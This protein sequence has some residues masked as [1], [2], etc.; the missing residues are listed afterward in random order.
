MSRPASA[1]RGTTSSYITTSGITDIVS[2][3]P[4]PSTSN[5]NGRR[6]KAVVQL[7][8]QSTPMCSIESHGQTGVADRGTAGSA[9][10][11]EKA[12]GPRERSRFRR[13]PHYHRRS[14][15]GL[16]RRSCE[17]RRSTRAASQRAG[18]HAA[19][20][21]APNG[22]QSTIMMPVRG[23]EL[24]GRRCRSDTGFVYVHHR[25]THPM[26]QGPQ[27]RWIP[28]TPSGAALPRSTDCR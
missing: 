27:A 26:D 25:P 9:E 14:D 17:T 24:E 12:N 28:T 6:I 3:P 2:P 22:N 11:R 7:T 4:I 21:I 20:L 19:S 8:K 15:Q 13:S 18:I 23:G 1:S 10:R 5:T 16:S